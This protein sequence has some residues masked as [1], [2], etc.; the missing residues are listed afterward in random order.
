MRERETR[1][2]DEEERLDVVVVGAGVAGLAAAATIHAAGLRVRVLEA[3]DRIGG[4]VHTIPAPDGGTPIELGAEFVHGAKSELF[5]LAREASREVVEEPDEHHEITPTAGPTAIALWDDLARAMRWV[6]EREPDRSLGEVLATV[7]ATGEMGRERERLREFVEGFHAADVASISANSLAQGGPWNDPAS[8][9]SFRFVDGYE[10][11]PRHLVRDIG[12]AIRPGRVVSRV[13][14]S[15]G[16]VRVESHGAGR[17][18]GTTTRAR[19]VILAIPLGVLLAPAGAEGAIVIDPEPGQAREAARRLGVGQV[20]RITAR[21][22]PEAR[23]AMSLP[24][25]FLHTDVDGLP[26]WW[27][28]GGAR[29]RQLVGWAG[30]PDADAHADVPDDLLLARSLDALGER[31][32]LRP[33]CLV[34]EVESCHAH[35]WRRDPFARGAYSYPLVGGA[36]A[37]EELARPVEHTLFLAGEACAPEGKNGTVDGAIASGRASAREV[38]RVLGGGRPEE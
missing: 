13:T 29:S 21:L 25:G 16:D 14:W 26:V 11:V 15:R 19:A 38:L 27:T 3:R 30:G 4:R 32:G 8:R 5:T 12:D 28:R 31:L 1:R 18:E 20:R 9:R 37:G 17:R 36:S 24:R 34:E 33:R 35:D 23:D 2:P 6:D 7:F 10:V 22:S